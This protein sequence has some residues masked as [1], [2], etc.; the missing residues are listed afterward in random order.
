MNKKC[1]L[2]HKIKV[3][4][5][6]IYQYWCYYSLTLTFILTLIICSW[7][8]FIEII[9]PDAW[10]IDEDIFEF[11]YLNEDDVST[12]DNE[13]SSTAT[14][15]DSYTTEN[16][17]EE[18]LPFTLDETVLEKAQELYSDNNNDNNEEMINW[19]DIDLEKEKLETESVITRLTEENNY[20]IDNISNQ[21]LTYCVVLDMIDGEIQC[22]FNKTIN[23]HPLAQLVGTWKIDSEIFTS[24]KVKNKLHTLGVCITHYN[25]DQNELHKS[26]L[27]QKRSIEKSWIYHCRCLFCNKYK[28][29]FS[30]ENN[31]L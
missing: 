27:K 12:L 23:Q 19:K 10:S 20:Q 25:F 24:T 6:I 22:C 17:S 16:T 4:T 11:N 13:L 7:F 28:Y 15:L 29:F 8:N 9:K 26:K 5:I 14:I 31:C 18:I 1:H 30:C 3:I 21:S 2:H